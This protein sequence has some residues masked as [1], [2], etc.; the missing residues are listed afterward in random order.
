MRGLGQIQ[1]RDGRGV[2]RVRATGGMLERD[3]LAFIALVVEALE[4]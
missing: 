2:A 1:L 3:P 4:A